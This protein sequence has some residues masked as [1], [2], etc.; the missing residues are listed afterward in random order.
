MVTNAT[1]QPHPNRAR[2]KF[3]RFSRTYAKGCNGLDRKGGKSKPPLNNPCPSNSS[4]VCSNRSLPVLPW[5]YRSKPIVA[6]WSI[7]FALA[8]SL[9]G[10]APVPVLYSRAFLT[11]PILATMLG[12]YVCI[13]VWRTRNVDWNG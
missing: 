13:L 1:S 7:V 5:F 11:G 3:F 10:F 2:T 8:S 9:L 4:R 6:S 12:K